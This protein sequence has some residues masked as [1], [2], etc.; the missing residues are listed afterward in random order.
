M[1]SLKIAHIREQ[2]QDM[3]IAPLDG[4]FGRKPSADQH[5]AIEDIQRAA[6]SAGLRGTVVPV[7][8]GSGGRFTFIAPQQW[9]PFFRSID[10]RWVHANVNRTLTW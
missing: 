5:D 8:D 6:R 7:W 9:H 10:M 4:S 2:G 1:P 3:I